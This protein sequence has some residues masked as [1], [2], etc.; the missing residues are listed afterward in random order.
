[1]A[2]PQLRPAK[3]VVMGVSGCGKSS[4]GATLAGQIGAVFLDADD[5][6]PAQNVVKMAAG[7]ALTDQDR[8]PWLDVLRVK[9]DSFVAEGEKV[10]LACSALKRAYRDR[11]SCE[12]DILFIHLSGEAALIHKRMQARENHYMPA[13][14]LKSQ[15]LALEPPMSDEHSLTLPITGSV[16]NIAMRALQQMGL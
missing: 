12:D 15:F 3:I 16:T 1:L 13:T 8:W 7:G 5:F 4:V 6:H 14:L 9:M 11:L 10:V 2:T